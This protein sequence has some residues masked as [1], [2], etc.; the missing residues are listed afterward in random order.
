MWWTP[1]VAAA[2]VVL[3]ARYCW[4]LLAE[5]R[6]IRNEN[7]ALKKDIQTMLD[8]TQAV[9]TAVDKAIA[10]ITQAQATLAALRAQPT[11]DAKTI[12]DL[13]ATNGALQ[14]QLTAAM[15][16]VP[17]LQAAAARLASA[18]DDLSI[19]ADPG[20]PAPAPTT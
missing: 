4:G 13:T 10:A 6:E 19:D 9:L 1:L 20:S 18:A 14:T 5:A 12:A 2:L 11:T 8:S 3:F 7:K 15:D 16:D 17:V